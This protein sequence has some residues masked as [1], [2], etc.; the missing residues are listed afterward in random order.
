MNSVISTLKTN[1]FVQIGIIAIVL[2][3]LYKYH[4]KDKIMAMVHPG[5]VSLPMT[6]VNTATPSAPTPTS[7]PTPAPMSAPIPD[8][9]VEKFGEASFVPSTMAGASNQ[10]ASDPTESDLAPFNISATEKQILEKISTGASQ[11]TAGDLL[12]NYDDAA[13]FSQE[14]PVSKILKDQ[15]FL[16]SGYSQGM[17]TISSSKRIPY[18]DFRENILIPKDNTISPWNMSALEEGLTQRGV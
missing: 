10:T 8:S 9:K 13:T 7:T 4:I 14:N 18:N 11:L 16:I 3:I 5:Y 12:P 1:H 6:N 17:D 15:N 2:Y